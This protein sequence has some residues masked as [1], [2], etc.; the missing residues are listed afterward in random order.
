VVRASYSETIGRP[1]WNDI[2]G[3]AMLDGQL[4]F[5]GGTGRSGD[6]SLKPLESTN[7]DLSLEWYYGEGSYASVGYFRKEISNFISTIQTVETP[8]EMH[9]PV[10]VRCGTSAHRG[11]VSPALRTKGHASATTSLRITRRLRA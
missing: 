7:Y 8:F 2:Q 5:D 6:P 9:T 4:R 3:G 10:A 1:G 11:G